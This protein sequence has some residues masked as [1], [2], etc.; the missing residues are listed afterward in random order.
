VKLHK[1]TKTNH[2]ADFC[3]NFFAEIEIHEVTFSE[4]SAEQFY[5]RVDYF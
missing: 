4:I 3:N 2:A 1:V 5:A